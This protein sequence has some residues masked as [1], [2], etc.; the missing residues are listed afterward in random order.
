MMSVEIVTPQGVEFTA[1]RVE[2]VV[3]RRR[4]PAHDPGSEIVICP[5]H[6]PLLMQTQP[7]RMRITRGGQLTECYV[8]GGVLEVYRDR[9][10][11]VV[12]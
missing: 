12:T 6:A 9:I 1:D 3:F 8:A 10:T 11:L 2:R 7:S 5:H 4:E